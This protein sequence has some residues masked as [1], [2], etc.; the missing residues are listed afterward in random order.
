MFKAVR[1]TVLTIAATGALLACAAGTATATEAR[2]TTDRAD[3]SSVSD[4]SSLPGLTD[5]CLVEVLE[6]DLADPVGSL[7]AALDNPVSSA[8]PALTCVTD[9]VNGVLQELPA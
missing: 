9:L 8:A 1:K 2:A 6:K 7:L 4:L 3:L 5:N